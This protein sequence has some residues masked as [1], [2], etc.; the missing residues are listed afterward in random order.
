MTQENFPL[1]TFKRL[2][3]PFYFYDT[4]LLR[5]TIRMAVAESTRYGY[6]IHYAVKANAN[7]RILSIIGEYGIGADC[8]SGGEIQAALNAGFPADKIVFAGVGK[9]DWEI[10]LGLDNTIFCFNVESLPELEIINQLAAAK[11]KTAR[12]ALRINPEVDAHTHHHITTGMK[13]NKFGINLEQL[14]AVLDRLPSLKHVWLIGIHFHIGSQLTEIEP[15]QKLCR[16]ASEIQQTFVKRGIRLQTVNFGGGLGINYEH[17]DGH[18]IPDFKTYFEAFHTHF[19]V[20]PGQEIHFEPGRSIVGQCGSLISKVLYVKEGSEKKFVILD[21]GFTELIRPALYDAYHQIEN[22]TSN[23]PEEM[24]D[25][26]GPIC[27][28][29]DCF[30]KQIPLNQAHRGDIIAIR[31]AGAYGEIMASQYNCRQLPVAYFS[32][33]IV[34]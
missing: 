4:K 9:A 10:N 3:T 8:V 18:W 24:Y 26:V 13:E 5:E 20:L 2:R 30:A 27:E 11:G 31:S 15:F 29:S 33:S 19:P 6:H 1:E 17:P 34:P 21:A 23:E 14:D 28:S 16:R 7:P 25:V 22:L 32:E 12:I